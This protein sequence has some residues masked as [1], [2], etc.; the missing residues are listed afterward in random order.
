MLL[1]GFIFMVAGVLAS[2]VLFLS[3]LDL[4]SKMAEMGFA[5]Y[6][7][8]F[9]A[10]EN[11]NTGK[12]IFML[13]LV[14]IVLGVVLYFV[15]RAKN[16]EEK[17]PVIPAKVTKFFRGTFSEFKKIDWPKFPAV[18]RN[19]GVVLVM[20]AVTGLV[21]VLVDAGLSALIQLFLSL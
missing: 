16:K 4:F 12:V 7:D 15:G 17:N 1:W 8:A 6:V 10:T 2:L 3:N 14:A 11:L 20:C 9:F 19:T 13:A 18:V 5:A 21:V